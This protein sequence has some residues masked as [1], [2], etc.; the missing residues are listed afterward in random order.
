M[1][2]S[3]FELIQKMAP[4]LVEFDGSDLLL[5]N[6]ALKE[7]LVKE[8]NLTFKPEGESYRI[9]RN[10]K[11]IFECSL[12]ATF[13]NHIL[14]VS[15]ICKDIASRNPRILTADKYIR[16]VERRFRYPFPAFDNYSE[17]QS[18]CYPFLSISKL[19]LTRAMFDGKQ[20]TT[21][22]LDEIGQFLIANDV[23]GLESYEFYKQLAP[24]RYSFRESEKRQVRE[25]MSFLGQKNY[26][27][28]KNDVLSLTGLDSS[29][30]E[31]EFNLLKPREIAVIPRSVYQSAFRNDIPMPHGVVL[32]PQT[33]VEDFLQIT[34]MES[35]EEDP[36][37]ENQRSWGAKAVAEFVSHEGK[38][39]ISIHRDR[40][41]SPIVRRAYISSNPN[42]TCNLC[43][44]NMHEEYPWTHYLLEIHHLMPLAANDENGVVATTLDDVVGL[45]PSCHRAVH[46]FYL[47]YLKESGQKDFLSK[48]EATQVYDMI[49]EQKRAGI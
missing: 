41:R 49:K 9:D 20:K 31:S 48:Q 3:K 29:L 33:R 37:E 30:Y 40:E 28:Y 24:K 27:H 18:I 11:R 10:Y 17:A 44:R 2:Y 38:K 16:E 23:D 1:Q 7:K 22:T 43:G 4:I 8:T 13:D 39:R 47:Q 32:I 12:L 14:I 36:L 19:L 6:T 21:L 34:A 25:M 42:P 35:Y 15:E 26:F 5:K 46:A 45:C